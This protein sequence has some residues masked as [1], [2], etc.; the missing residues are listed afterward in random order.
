MGAQL[1][2][3]AIF[4][5]LLVL[6]LTTPSST[7]LA[8]LYTERNDVLRANRFEIVVGS[9]FKWDYT[10]AVW[11]SAFVS[12]NDEIPGLD[13]ICSLLSSLT[14]VDH[15]VDS[16]KYH[17]K[18]DAGDNMDMNNE[19]NKNKNAHELELVSVIG[20][21]GFLQLATCTEFA[22]L[23][24][25]DGNINELTKALRLRE[26]VSEAENPEE[27]ANF[28]RHMDRIDKEIRRKGSDGELDAV[29]SF[30]LPLGLLQRGARLAPFTPADQGGRSEEGRETEPTT[31]RYPSSPPQGDGVNGFAFRY[32]GREVS[33][34]TLLPPSLYPELTNLWSARNFSRAASLL[35]DRLNRRLF[36]GLPPEGS[37]DAEVRREKD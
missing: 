8:T 12:T 33:M 24:L 7:T 30:Y 14:A 10:P 37:L 28:A 15:R 27:A 23:T 9:G 11:S 4:V 19:K 13:A 22:R 34:E 21:M 25:F 20:G 17:R 1:P 2:S 3:P 5:M 16:D 26:M 18:N 35:R 36:V 32:D 29:S 31:S 6:V